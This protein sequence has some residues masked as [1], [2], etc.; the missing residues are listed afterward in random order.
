MLIFRNGTIAW[1]QVGDVTFDETGN[2]L[3]ALGE[4]FTADCFIETTSEV[5][6]SRNDDGYFNNASYAV[7]VD[8][9]SV[10]DGF[11]PQNVHL[12]DNHKGDL[13]DFSV[14]RIEYYDLTHS[15]RLWV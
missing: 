8:A 2:P 15:I 14:K 5:R 12:T 13:G 9:D 1:K 6:N 4:T 11:A 10:G 3:V 7:M